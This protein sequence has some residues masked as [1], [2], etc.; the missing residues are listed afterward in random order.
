MAKRFRWRWVFRGRVRL[1]F[2]GLTLAALGVLWAESMST[3]HGVFVRTGSWAVSIGVSGGTLNFSLRSVK[4]TRQV[5]GRV[6]LLE[7]PATPSWELLPNW[8][9]SIYGSTLFAQIPLWNVMLVPLAALCFYCWSDC[10]AEKM[11]LCVRCRYD[12][13]AT[14]V[15]EACPECGQVGRG[16]ANVREQRAAERRGRREAQG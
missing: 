5:Q 1:W 12:L 16:W 4:G 13:A 7:S 15:T 10:R 6:L 8:G 3:A 11:G 2:W 14:P 9:R